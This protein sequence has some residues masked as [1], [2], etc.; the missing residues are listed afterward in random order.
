VSVAVVGD[1]KMKS[2]NRQY[3]GVDKSTD[4]LSFPYRDKESNQDMGEFVVT[5][6]EGVVLGD[7]VIS[8]PKVV[9]QAAEK[10]VLV[11]DE[12]EFLVEHGLDHLL[13]RHHG[14]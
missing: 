8:Y 12:V 6:D 2:L 9:K 4:V 5:E 14:E 7:I 3:H 13:G 1:R 11:D 10:G